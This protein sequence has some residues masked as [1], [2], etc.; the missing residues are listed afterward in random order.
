MNALVKATLTPRQRE[1][2]ELMDS[3]WQLGL[4]SKFITLHSTTPRAWLQKGGCGRGGETKDVNMK[5]FYAL[6]DKG[7]LEQLDQD[8]LAT[9]KLYKLSRKAKPNG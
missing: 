3:G 1:V 7:L 5:T 8:M 4:S 6:C 2:I 9:P